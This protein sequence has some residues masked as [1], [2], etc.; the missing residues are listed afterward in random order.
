MIH[1]SPTGM[2][3]PC[4]ELAPVAHY[5]SFVP[6]EFAG[7]NCNRCFDSCRAEPQAPITLRRAAELLGLA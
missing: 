5:S 6:Q 3:Q 4:A 2:V 7:T 1:V